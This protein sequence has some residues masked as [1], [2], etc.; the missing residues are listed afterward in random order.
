[1]VVVGSLFF[2]PVECRQDDERLS[3]L[4]KLEQTQKLSHLL[5]LVRIKGMK[6]AANYF[7]D[8]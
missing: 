2:L 5:R 7:Y 4:I 3:V 6:I 1:M 8:F